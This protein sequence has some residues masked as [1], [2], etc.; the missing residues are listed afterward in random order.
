MAV[1]GSACGQLVFSAS[2]DGWVRA[3]RHR[4][5]AGRESFFLSVS[6]A[7]S[8][9]HSLSLSIYLSL[10]LL[11]SNKEGKTEERKK[12]RGGRK[13]K[14]YL[15]KKKTRRRHE[16]LHACV[17]PQVRAW[18]LASGEVAWAVRHPSRGRGVGVWALA[19]APDG[20]A[21]FSGS[22]S[23]TIVHWRLAPAPGGAFPPPTLAM[24]LEGHTDYVNC[25][26]VHPTNKV[27]APTDRALVARVCCRGGGADKAHT[28]RRARWHRRTQART[29][30]RT[31]VN[32]FRCAGCVCARV[33]ACVRVCSGR[34]YL[35]A[36]V[37]CACVRVRVCVRMRACV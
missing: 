24:T 4:G 17:R 12:G 13:R 5:R 22:R 23:R 7:L 6:F 31:H 9:S 29:H 26:A 36:C 33:R 3:R 35:C 34:V 15:K 11:P 14:R 1:V 19:A 30:T 21:L 25:L 8:L 37:R 2:E 32:V 18:V 20:S 10:S 16:G 27:R 28:G